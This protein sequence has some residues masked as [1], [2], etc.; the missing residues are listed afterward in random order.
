MKKILYLLVLV[1]ILSISTAARAASVYTTS[2]GQ[3]ITDSPYLS[4]VLVNQDPSS[5]NPGEYV[6]L[7]F[8]IENKGTGDAKNVT[9][10]LTPE[11]PFSLDPGTSPI[12]DI[13]TI[14]GLQGGNDAFL[15]KYKVKV[16]KDAIN[17][18]NEIKL[19]YSESDIN[20]Y[21][22]A[23]N[24]IVANS[25]TDFDVVAQDSTTLAI[26]NIGDN[27]AQSVIV[28]I[29]DQPNFR[30]NG[31]SATI[32]GNLNS[33]DYTLAT[34]QIFS[35][36]TSNVS[37][38]ITSNIPSGTSSGPSD[39]TVEISYTDILGI[40]RTV[41]KNVSYGF[42][43][44]SFSITGRTFTRTGQSALPISN[45]LLYIIIGVAGIVVIVVFIKIRSRKKK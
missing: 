38:N 36:R 4:L 22:Q 7:L 35:T 24:V 20:H 34:F 32:I 5:A 23:F 16:D 3:F 29:P 25:R 15:V 2:S 8:K 43:T 30:V 37:S 44:N 10:E 42:N 19:E 28:R 13:G 31:T 27:T 18:E 33:G 14:N 39:L 40:R 21:T 26:A 41:D 17:G 12:T 45:G 9:L 6:N 11:Y 1:C